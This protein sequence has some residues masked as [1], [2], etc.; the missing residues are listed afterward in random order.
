M[1]SSPLSLSAI[2]DAVQ[3]VADVADVTSLRHIPRLSDQY[4]AQVFFKREDLQPVRSFKIRGSYNLIS[5]LSH[6]EKA[7]GIVAASAGNHAQGVALSCAKL[8][9]DGVIFMPTNAPRQ[10]INK[11][12]SFGQDRIEIR[13]LGATVDEALAAARE[14][15]Q[16]TGAVFVH[17]FDDERIIAGQATIAVEIWDQLITGQHDRVHFFEP[18]NPDKPVDVVIVPIGGGGLISGIA[19][20]LKAKNPDVKIIGVEPEGAASMKTSV[21]AGAVQTLD[22]ID[23]FCDGVALKSPGNLPL[24]IVQ[25][26]VD[27]IV[28]CPEGHAAKSMIELYQNE[29]I[30]AEPC[31]ALVVAALP[32]L[33]KKIKGKNVVCVMSGGNNDIARYPEVMERSLV[34]Q[35]LKHYFIVEFAQK[36]GK[37]H[38]FLDTV[39][40]EHTDIVR[41][42][43]MKKNNKE[44]GPA[45]V[46]IEL[47]SA[48]QYQ[49]LLQRMEASGL[50]YRVI[51]GSSDLHQFLV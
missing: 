22:S 25:E 4:Q 9:I 51:E 41:F 46:G 7:C 37:L 12:K 20:Y 35:G 44:T 48:E 39:L 50:H 10:K 8:G 2:A 21:Q 13:L 6:Q 34:W 49:P 47:D 43:Y 29:G 36:P 33:A 3:R 16:K 42:E 38:E 14:H 32:E 23:T 1:S 19:S 26:L 27:E 5:S 45:L 40:G 11:V 28:V 31:A 17:P 30:I 15:A 18:Q 24:S